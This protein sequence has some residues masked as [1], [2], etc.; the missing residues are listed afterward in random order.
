MIFDTIDG[1]AP[2]SKRIIYDTYD[3]LTSINHI[4]EAEGCIIPDVNHVKNTRTGRRRGVWGSK[5][6][7][8]GGNRVQMLVEDDYR[9]NLKKKMYK[10]AYSA[11]EMQLNLSQQ[12]FNCYDAKVYFDEDSNIG[13]G[14]CGM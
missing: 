8:N 13:D 6:I 3:V 14:I 4:V 10:D 5:N 11:K 12:I 7:N 2:S 1:V 9:A